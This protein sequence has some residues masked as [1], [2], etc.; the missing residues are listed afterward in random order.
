[1]RIDDLPPVP[2]P[3]GPAPDDSDSDSD[4]E[5]DDEL[6]DPA[7]G[8][9][10]PIAED[11]VER[12]VAGQAV[13]DLASAVKELIDNSLDAGATTIQIKLVN[14]GLELI[15]VS[16]D[17]S[18]IPKSSRPL[19]AMKHATSKIREFDDLYRDTHSGQHLGFR[20]EALFC[21]ANLS[22]NLI[23]TTRTERE[24][25][26][27]RLEYR[28]DGYCRGGEGGAVAAP[29]KVGTTVQVVKLFNSLPVRRSDMERRIKAQKAR[30]I[31]LMQ[32]YALLC[33][34]VRFN[35]VEVTNNGKNNNNNSSNSGSSSS[36]TSLQTSERSIRF[37]DTVSSVLGSKFLS[38]L[39]RCR[40]D[41]T[42]AVKSAITAK[43]A[44]AASASAAS[45][46]ADGDGASA[47]TAGGAAAAAAA[48]VD[49]NSILPGVFRIEGLISK[50]P[51]AT[52]GQALA[53]DLQF[54]SIN[55]RPVELPKISRSLGDV[56]RS[57][58]SDAAAGGSKG[59]GAGNS[60]SSRKRP[61]CVLSLFLPNHMYDVNLSPDKREVLLNEET[62][63]C[64]LIREALLKLWSEQTDG[65]FV[66][67]EVETMS[68]NASA[69]KKRK[70]SSAASTNAVAE[71][72][73]AET[74]A[75]AQ[76]SGSS[77][78]PPLASSTTP[79]RQR[80]RRRNAFVKNPEQV[81]GCAPDTELSGSGLSDAPNTSADADSSSSVQART[82]QALRPTSESTTM[83]SAMDRRNWE[84]TRLRF[85]R[86]DTTSQMEEIDK[87]SAMSSD[88]ASVGGETGADADRPIPTRSRRRNEESDREDEEPASK[89]SASKKKTTT[90][91]M[92]TRKRKAAADDLQ[93]FA[94]GAPKETSKSSESSSEESSNDEE[95]ELEEKVDNTSTSADAANMRSPSKVS[96]QE[97]AKDTDDD[98]GD[99]DGRDFTKAIGQI[100]SPEQF[101]RH[102]TAMRRNSIFRTL[103][104]SAAQKDAESVAAELGSSMED[105]VAPSA[106]RPSDSAP[107]AMQ[108]IQNATQNATAIGTGV[109][110]GGWAAAA[111]AV[112][113]RGGDLPQ[114]VT[115]PAQYKRQTSPKKRQRTQESTSESGTSSHQSNLSQA[116]PV[117]WGHFGGTSSVVN[118][119]YATRLRMESVRKSIKNAK[120]SRQGEDGDDS[121]VGDVY[122][123][124]TESSIADGDVQGGS[125][126]SASKKRTKATKAKGKDTQIKLHHNDFESMV[127]IGQFNLGFVL[128]R[129]RNNNLWILDQHACD[130]KFN[131]ERLCADTTIHEQRLIAPLPLEL[132]PS[133]ESCVLDNMDIFEKN[134]FRFQYD[135]TKPPRHR[136]SLTALP[137]SGS[138]GDGHRA[139]QFGAEDVGALCAILGADGASSSLG[140]VAGSGT[141]ADGSG[142]YG[143]NAVRRHGM[144]SSTSAIDG[145]SIVRLP[146]AIAMFASRACRSSIMIGTALSQKE[147][148]TVVRKMKN[149]NAPWDCAHGRPT[150]RHV[151]SLI[152]HIIS[153]ERSA[154]QHTAGP[155][156]AACSQVGG[157]DEVDSY[158][159]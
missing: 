26:G 139:V 147:M 42:D 59:G 32:G 39:C 125:A 3:P 150:L 100:H 28:Q 27:Q 143:N 38:G 73:D 146:K 58:N 87:L 61:A 121:A 110:T 149:V 113:R 115:T 22:E 63:I 9:I 155:N 21:L 36:K 128:C 133:E 80:M 37:E 159:E 16:D 112:S 19:V 127:V 134:G 99:S 106:A 137:H 69:G 103:E 74:H 45:V 71:D 152:E 140:F 120:N 129:C 46:S 105:T 85:N 119:A 142:L 135:E 156:L 50:A 111:A 68:N 24:E 123:E 92:R 82:P 12:I 4:S 132:S 15:E 124:P 86:A 130:E 30:L 53:R 23:V 148:E 136:L 98:A 60:A 51:A 70:G 31:K 47:N 18:G 116:E 102:R 81:G 11:T 91:K 43:K 7:D 20:G 117:S 104:T 66:R 62:M 10:V 79:P 35:L 72:T 5:D 90:K 145:P 41:L 13:S 54:F 75:Q 114:L 89:P 65:T 1:M 77:V 17:G 33:L 25:V 138:G 2:P 49:P 76:A 118:V 107:T 96:F 122:S 151:C 144:T 93:S 97:R 34:G 94:F 52:A 78:T 8:I 101:K 109:G 153:D 29:R 158:G 14:S 64:D 126:N 48:E 157:D 67:N 40:V 95:M 57:Y 108:V 44:M 154:I 6:L 83:V 88:G 131:F 141:G 84:Q 56:W 55:G